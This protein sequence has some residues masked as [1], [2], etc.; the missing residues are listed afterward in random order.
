MFGIINLILDILAGILAWNIADPDN[1][2]E[3]IGFLL[4]WG[5][6]IVISYIISIYI[7]G[8]IDGDFRKKH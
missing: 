3:F 4:I 8:F 5:V 1:F 7:M 6:F 2:A